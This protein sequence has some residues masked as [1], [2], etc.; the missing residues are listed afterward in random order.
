VSDF[1]VQSPEVYPYMITENGKDVSLTVTIGSQTINYVNTPESPNLATLSVYQNPTYYPVFPSGNT[2]D[3]DDVPVNSYP[4]YNPGFALSL[5]IPNDV[6]FSP[7][8]SVDAVS[9]PEPSTLTV[10]A[11]FGVLAVIHRRRRTSSREP[12]AR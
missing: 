1:N 9:A 10:F 6:I 8:T 3:V 12:I 2:I 5:G 4:G 7:I 11:M